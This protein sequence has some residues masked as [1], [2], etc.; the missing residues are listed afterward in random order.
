M[1]NVSQRKIS[2]DLA[3]LHNNINGA[4]LKKISNSVFKTPN[5][6]QYSSDNSTTFSPRNSGLVF[7]NIEK[8]FPSIYR[9]TFMGFKS[10]EKKKKRFDNYGEE[11]KKGGNHKIVFAD[12]LDFVKKERKNLHQRIKSSFSN[13]GKNN[14]ENCEYFKNIKRSNSFEI[15]TKFVYKNINPIINGNNKEK[16]K[17]FN[18]VDIIDFKSTKEENKLN[19]YFFKKKMEFTD[20][21]HVSCSCYC[22]IF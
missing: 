12:E 17:K 4:F 18:N 8:E 11:I 20:E 15:N 9:L 21:E 22:C 6:K 13:D 1:Q 7:S 19:T 16:S 3:L 5:I 2:S 14:E 10:F